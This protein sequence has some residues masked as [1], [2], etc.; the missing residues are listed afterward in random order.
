MFQGHGN[1]AGVVPH[2]CPD[3]K[4]LSMINELNYVSRESLEKAFSS[5]T[6]KGHTFSK[7]SSTLEFRFS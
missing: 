2:R 4:I 1:V 3:D 7:S 5:H 6:R